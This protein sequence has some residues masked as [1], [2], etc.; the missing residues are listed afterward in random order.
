MKNSTTIFVAGGT[1]GHVFAANGMA[2]YVNT[3]KII[4]TDKRGEKYIDKNLFDE[5]HV[6]PVKN[7]ILFNMYSFVKSFIKSWKELKKYKKSPVVGFGSYASLPT[8]IMAWVMKNPLYLYQADQLIGKANK[9]LS[10]MAKKIFTTSYAIH[11][12]KA[13]CVGLI[14]RSNIISYPIETENELKILIMGGSLSSAFWK[15]VI[16]SALHNLPKEILQRIS[17]HQQVGEDKNYF[18]KSYQEIQLKKVVLEEFVD[19]SKALPWSNLVI[20]RAGMGTISDLTASMRPGLLIPWANAKD[21]HQKYN[22]Q[23]WTNSG[24]GWW[25]PEHEFTASYLKNFITNLMNEMEQKQIKNEKLSNSSNANIN[26]ELQQKSEALGKW[27]PVHGGL[28]AAKIIYNENHAN[29]K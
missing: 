29:D 7:N 6:L 21:N 25:A 16:P 26:S 14:P 28:F 22:A 11:H 27:M 8:C 20:A 24:G 18:A 4:F 17:I 2:Y 10:Y 3:R 12:Q 23:W 15:V 1:A 19:T 5:I 13:E 9:L